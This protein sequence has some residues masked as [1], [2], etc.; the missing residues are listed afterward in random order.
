MEHQIL[1]KTGMI[2]AIINTRPGV[3]PAEPIDPDKPFFKWQTRRIVK[4]CPNGFEWV[5]KHPG[6]T[7]TNIIWD[8]KTEQWITQNIP[9]SSDCLVYTGLMERHTNPTNPFSDM[10]RYQWESSPFTCPYGQPGDNLWVRETWS[11]IGAEHVKPS[12]IALGYPVQYKADDPTKNWRV[13]KWRPSIFMPRWASRFNLEIKGIRVERLQA[14][15]EAD[16]IAEGAARRWPGPGPEPYKRDLVGVYAYL[17]DSINA[18]R[19]YGWNTNPYVWVIE[20][21]R[22]N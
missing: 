13:E 19:G 8:D 4:P 5:V 9:V 17:W 16:V 3:W 21:M 1:F 14:I 15:T 7:F 10:E 11:C 22:I 2:Q 6:D 12:E 18:K 20:F